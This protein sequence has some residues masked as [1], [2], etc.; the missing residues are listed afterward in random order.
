MNLRILCLTCYIETIY[1][2]TLKQNKIVEH[3]VTTS[4]DD[5]HNTCTVPCEKS[6][7]VSFASLKI[8]NIAASS[9]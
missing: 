9:A 6:E 8:K 1:T 4:Y 2:N 7:T 5:I 3:A